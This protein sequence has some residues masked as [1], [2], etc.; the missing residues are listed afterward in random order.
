MIKVHFPLA[1]D[2]HQ[3]TRIPTKLGGCSRGRG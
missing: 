3:D 2:E 1:L